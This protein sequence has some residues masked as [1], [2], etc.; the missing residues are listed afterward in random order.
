[1]AEDMT[2]K[3]LKESAGTIDYTA[4]EELNPEP[5]SHIAVVVKNTKSNFWATVKRE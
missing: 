5:G 4:L 1:M 2:M 3:V